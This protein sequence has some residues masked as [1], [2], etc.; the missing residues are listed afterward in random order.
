[1][2]GPVKTRSGLRLG[3]F[4][5]PFRTRIIFGD[6]SLIFAEH[7]YAKPFLGM[8][9]SVGPGAVID[10]NQHQHGIQ[11]DRGKSIRSHAMNLAVQV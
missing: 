8:K 11:R 3:I 5:A 4:M 9:M 10:A 1:M 7:I 2:A 6:S